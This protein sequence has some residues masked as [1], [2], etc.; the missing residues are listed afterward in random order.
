M[1]DKALLSGTKVQAEF[2]WPIR[3]PRRTIYREGEHGYSMTEPLGD[4]DFKAIQ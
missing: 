4:T 2:V 1:H 3:I